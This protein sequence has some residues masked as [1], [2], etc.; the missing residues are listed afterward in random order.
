MF[1]HEL[2][3]QRAFKHLKDLD[4]LVKDWIKGDHHSIRY[5]RDPKDD[6]L[7]PLVTAEKPPA[8][9]FGLLIGE[10]LHNLRSGLDCLAFQLMN[11][12]TT[13]PP[14][15]MTEKSEFPIFGDE[16]RSGLGGQGA[17]LFRDNGRPKILGWHP[18]AQTVVETLQ[19]YHRGNAYR[20]HPLW[21]LHDL[22]RVNKHRLIHATVA[23]FS[24]LG[25]DMRTSYNFKLGPGMLQSLEGPI[26][27]D[28]PIGRLPA[29]RT[30]TTRE[31]N[32]D[33]VVPLDVA[34]D[35]GT[36]SVEYESVLKTLWA[37]Y[38]E[39]GSTET[40]LRPYL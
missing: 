17:N 11:A 31:M 6:Y 29:W 5:E 19:P 27:T 36:P 15:E 23:V 33:V 39:V 20:T 24:G 7:I 34:F 16:N 30:D 9:P 14:I 13:S 37:I 40:T 4:V 32:V 18:G 38:G 35:K 25:I 10:I 12:H 1:D 28:T 8:D 2:K 21:V 3:I 26:E 22:D